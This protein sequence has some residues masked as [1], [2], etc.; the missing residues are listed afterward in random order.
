VLIVVPHLD[1]RE[2]GGEEKAVPWELGNVKFQVRE[3]KSK[4]KML[5]GERKRKRHE[6]EREIISK[7]RNENRFPV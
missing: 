6:R 2:C 1:E 3:R 4:K 5:G 7:E